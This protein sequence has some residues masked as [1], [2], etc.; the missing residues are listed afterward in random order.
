MRTKSTPSNRVSP[1]YPSLIRHVTKASQRPVVGSALNWQGQPQLQLQLANSSPAIR[2]LIFVG[3]PIFLL[4]HLTPAPN[5]EM[6]RSGWV[7]G[8]AL[9]DTYRAL[10]HGIARFIPRGFEEGQRQRRRETEQ[11][12]VNRGPRPEDAG[13]RLT[14][15]K[16]CEG[17]YCS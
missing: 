13:A 7:T 4:L 15:G 10:P 1:K 11:P 12:A 5:G 17:A 14:G 16:M 8:R 9:T 2:H 3:S 6:S